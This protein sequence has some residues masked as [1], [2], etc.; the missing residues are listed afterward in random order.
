MTSTAIL[1]ADS[2]TGRRKFSMDEEVWIVCTD[3]NDM[4]HL[5]YMMQAIADKSGSVPDN[6]VIEPP[7]QRVALNV[8]GHPYR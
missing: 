3:M 8:D 5:K 1:L 2:G 7:K 4:Y 6:W